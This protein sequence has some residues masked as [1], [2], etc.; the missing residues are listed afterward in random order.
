MQYLFSLDRSDELLDQFINALQ[1]EEASVGVLN[2][3]FIGYIF[4]I[5]IKDVVAN[6]NVHHIITR[7][8]DIESEECEVNNADLIAYNRGESYEFGEF[9]TTLFL[10]EKAKVSKFIQL[11]KLAV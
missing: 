6:S 8:Y 4:G 3:N 11:N 9:D 7:F 1:C 10:S 2:K 5:S